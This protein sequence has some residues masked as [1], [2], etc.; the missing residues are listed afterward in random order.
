MLFSD[1]KISIL[2]KNNCFEGNLIAGQPLEDVQFGSNYQIL[3]VSKDCIYEWDLRTWRLSNRFMK[4]NAFTKLWTQGDT[5]A[6]G[7]KLGVVSLATLSEGL[8]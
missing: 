5:L 3:G 1:N 7:N 4:Y 6:I 2:D 8:K